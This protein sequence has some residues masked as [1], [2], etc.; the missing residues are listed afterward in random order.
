MQQQV[1]DVLIVDIEGA[2]VDIRLLRQLPDGGRQGQKGLIVHQRQPQLL[3][4]L[5]YPSVNG[6]AM[7]SQHL[8]MLYDKLTL[9]YH[10]R[11]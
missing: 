5:F 10:I 7:H 6:H 9:F 1:V 2:A 3:L 8:R 4:G 11:P